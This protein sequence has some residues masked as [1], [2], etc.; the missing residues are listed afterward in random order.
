MGYDQG[1][2]FFRSSSASATMMA[3][4][5]YLI[6]GAT[7]SSVTPYTLTFLSSYSPPAPTAN[8]RTAGEID[9]ASGYLFGFSHITNYALA[10]P[11][12]YTASYTVDLLGASGSLLV[13]MTAATSDA[14]SAMTDATSTVSFTASGNHRVGWMLSPLPTAAEAPAAA[15]PEPATWATMVAGFGL[16]GGTLRRRR[17]VAALA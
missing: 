17:T 11:T 10:D 4:F 16:L 2:N 14:G 1:G 12:A 9:D 15:V 8:Q 6:V 5:D 13:S 7:A 3:E